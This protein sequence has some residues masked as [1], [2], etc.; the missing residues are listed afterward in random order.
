MD[1]W[2]TDILLEGNAYSSTCTLVSND[3]HRI[4]VDTGLSI[5][6]TALVEA[7]AE[8]RLVPADIDFVINTH[9][10]LDH[11]SNNVIF[12]R[13]VILM[14]RLEWEWTREFYDA[15]FSTRTPERIAEKFY[16]EVH[17][18]GLSTRTIRNVARLARLFWRPER[19]GRTGQLVWLESAALPPGLEIIDTPGHTPHHISVRVPTP[20]PT[21][22][23]G[24]AVLAEDADAK[25]KTMIPFSRARFDASRRALIERGEVI[26]PGH[27]AAFRAAARRA[28]P[29]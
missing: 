22:I 26:V 21:I 18:Y 15:M 25:V 27:G 1:S 3:R 19:V 29:A 17:S 12:E 23:A 7:L 8:R 16:P 10:H 24:D 6:E 11:C 2:R 4:L 20:E 14:S 5:Q 9:L 28:R 13:A